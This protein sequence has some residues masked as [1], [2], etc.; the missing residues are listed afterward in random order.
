VDMM[1]FAHR[2]GA[3]HNRGGWIT[4]DP[5]D[6]FGVIPGQRRR[7]RRSEGD[8]NHGL[9]SS[10]YPSGACGAATALGRG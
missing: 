10:G 2:S 3:R 1:N 4:T 9:L 7:S 5:A 8:P 6:Q